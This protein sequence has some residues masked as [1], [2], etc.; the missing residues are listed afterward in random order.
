MAPQRYA[1]VGTGH[2]SLSMFGLPLCTDFPETAQLVALCD[3]N[4]LRLAAYAAELPASVPGF[5][6]FDRMMSEVALDAVVVCSID[7]THAEYV[8]AALQAG[9]HVVS[10]KPLCTTAGQC[11]AILDAAQPRPADCRVTHN[12]RYAAGPTRIRELLTSGRLGRVLFVQFDE[13]LDR[14]HGADYFR[15]WHRHKANSGGL[16]VHKACHH[17]DCLNWWIDSTPAW[18]SAQ[19][20]LSFYGANGPFRG[21]RCSGCEYAERCPLY[22]NLFERAIYRK[23]YQESESA[24]GY[25]R[26]GCVFDPAID[27]QDQMGVLIRYENGVE[28]SYSLLAY[29]PYESQRVVI[30]CERGRI[31]YVAQYNTGFA[32]GASRVPGIEETVGETLKLYIP[33]EGM[34][35]I[36]LQR[37][38]GGHGGADPQLRADLFGRAWDAEP[39]DRT[40]SLMDAVQAVLIGVA[41]DKSITTGQPV[42]VQG[43]L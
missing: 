18:V 29:S 20:R 1:I 42:E 9:K 2:R 32:A 33:G 26:D 31:E 11:R 15:R 22:A 13:T 36:P 4:P 27:I 41:A 43:L 8:V 12:A 10:E 5:T 38:E 34:E 24:D 37:G 16:P 14:C 40:A 6:H 35:A 30:E 19:G 25:V 17:F 3:P 39:T 21:E 7:R 28:A 23:L